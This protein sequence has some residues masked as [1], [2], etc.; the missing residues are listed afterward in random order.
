M[1]F[2]PP[3]ALGEWMC[4]NT[5]GLNPDDA[6]SGWKHFAIA[7]KPGGGVTWIKC[8]YQSIRGRIACD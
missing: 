8:E 5:A 1:R 3:T 2:L 7:P 6:Q 4:R